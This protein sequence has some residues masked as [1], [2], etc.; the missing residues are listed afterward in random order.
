MGLGFARSCRVI[1]FANTEPFTIFTPQMKMTLITVGKTDVHW[2]K[3]GLELY[4][5]RLVHYVQ[6]SVN[7]IPELKNVSSLSKEQIKSRE[8][9]LILSMVKTSDDVILLDEHGKEF[10]SLDFASWLQNKMSC[11]GRDI[12][13]VIGGAYGFS[14]AVYSRANSKISLSAMTFSHQMV[15]TIFAEQL[16]RAFTIMKGEPYH[17]E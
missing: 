3:E 11:S 2:V 17:H 6:F 14:D 16:Y 13:F 9:E 10:R 15:R 4:R 12:V 1:F 8:G 5:S 7:E